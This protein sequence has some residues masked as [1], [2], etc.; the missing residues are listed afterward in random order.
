MM[1]SSH[2][3]IGGLI[4]LV[5]IAIRP[6]IVPAVVLAG[7]AGGLV[8]DLDMVMHHRRTLHF[9]VLG[10]MATLGSGVLA[11]VSGS[12]PILFLAVFFA[13]MTVHCLS[14]V[15][16]EGKVFR[17]WEESD[18]RGAYDHLNDRWLEARGWLATGTVHDL[19]IG[20]VAGVILI[21]AVPTLAVPVGVLMGVSIVY[22][23][24]LRRLADVISDDHD[25]LESFVTSLVRSE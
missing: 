18:P 4:G 2:A 20:L 24:T 3:L 14:D 5:S 13:G 17:H 12:T 9:P 23:A 11:I 16:G 15:L 8:P 6:D 1:I 22:A 25:T 19:W 7:M 10:L 21:A